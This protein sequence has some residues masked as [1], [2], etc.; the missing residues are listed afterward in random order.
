MNEHLEL[1]KQLV[2]NRF[3]ANYQRE[4]DTFDKARDQIIMMAD[5]FSNGIIEQYPKRFN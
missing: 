1:V 5:Y 3:A 2:S 4:A